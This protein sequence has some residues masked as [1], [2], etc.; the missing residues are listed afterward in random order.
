MPHSLPIQIRSSVG[1]RRR[2]RGA[3]TLWMI[4]WLPCLL[5]LFCVLVGIA[6]L[7]LARVELENGLEASALAAVKHWG[8]A[9]GGDTL[10][11][12]MVGVN[13]AKANSVRRVPIGIGTN[14]DPNDG[15]N[16]NEFC[17]PGH[18]VP[19]GNLVFGAIDDSN[20]D[21]IIFNAGIRPSCAAGLVL[22]DASA[23]GPGDLSNDNAWGISFQCSN[24]PPPPTLRITRIIINLQAQ[25]GTTGVF[26]FTS[27]PPV[28][29]D[30]APEPFIS[31]TC[32]QQ[33]YS[34]PDNVG[35]TDP[36][37]QI[38]FT[39]TT[40]LSPTLTIDF[41][42]DL[43]PIGG[44][45]D[46]FAPGDRFRFGALTRDVSSGNG[47]D[48]GDGIGRDGVG[49]TV[50]FNDGSFSSGVFIDNNTGGSNDCYCPP[51]ID[52]CDG[53]S[54][55]VNNPLNIPNLPCPPSSANNNN[56]QSYAL[57]GG[58]GNLKFGVRAQSILPVQTLGGVPFVGPLS[59]YCAK[60]KSTA[61]Y[62]CITRR[63][64]LIRIDTFI[65]PGP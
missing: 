34:Q 10:I 11:P 59:E 53:I 6:N 57:I 4:I 14:Y 19:T 9:G 58:G 60:A 39:P 64:R 35:F 50:F 51:L 43:N 16:Q 22:L 23:Q 36:A 2:R 15:V 44:T 13:Y 42:P 5:A 45:D 7:W 32:N 48:N 41:F 38:V 61:V 28:V 25:P 37:T 31:Q 1:R 54:F 3:V 17:E 30:N 65:C 47:Q 18:L 8:D 63:P 20:P 46:G 27:A 56:G 21:N 12:R 29:S 55:I 40:G 52:P 62:D 26:D 24:P 33:T 49:V